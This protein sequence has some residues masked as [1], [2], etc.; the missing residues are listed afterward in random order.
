MALACLE[1]KSATAQ[2][3]GTKSGA[4]ADNSSVKYQHYGFR[5]PYLKWKVT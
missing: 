2:A 5:I 4:T 3:F 1:W